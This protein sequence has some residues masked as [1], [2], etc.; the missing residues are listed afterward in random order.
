MPETNRKLRI[1]CCPANHGGCAYYRILMPMQKLAEKCADKVEIRFDDNPLGV[2]DKIKGIP[3]DF[4]YENMNWAD[5]VFTH[6][7]HTRG[8][9]YTMEIVRKADELGKFTHYDTDD[10]LTDLY[11]GHRLYDVYKEQKLEEF[12]KVIYHH[13]DLVSVTQSK[14]AERIKPFVSKALVVIKN[15]IDF[16]LPCWNHRWEPAPTKKLT[17]FGWVGGIHHEEDVKEFRSV[18]LGMN[19]KNGVENLRW[20]FHGRPPLQKGEKGDWQQDVWNNYEKY[21]M[22]GVHPRQRKNIFFGRALNGGEY[23]VMFRDMDV[24]LAPLQMNNFNDSKSDIK[25]MEC[26]RYGIPLVATDVGCYSENIINGETG[27]LI[28][29]DNPREEWVK[30]LSLLHKDKKLRKEMGENLRQIVN[31][32]FDVNKHVAERYHLYRQLMSY[33][34]QAM[35]QRKKDEQSNS[36]S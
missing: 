18:V 16:D 25:L 4:S 3:E 26:G 5:I 32:K 12:T 23:G 15:A 22:H 9:P 1:L 8:G 35:K 7:I 36:N 31:E 17:R 6:N 28:P 10:L 13:A 33:K 30:K 21:L 29:P 24:S 11:T 19:S 2:D 27:F 14:F 20:T 34:D